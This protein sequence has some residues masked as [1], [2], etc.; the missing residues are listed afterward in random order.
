LE[1]GQGYYKGKGSYPILPFFLAHKGPCI[2]Q[3]TH[4]KQEG[5]SAS[6]YVSVGLPEEATIS[7]EKAKRAEL[8]YIVAR[9]S[10]YA[11]SCTMMSILI[12]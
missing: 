11:Y 12:C 1:G 8:H 6:Y 10:I 5:G 3:E 7:D 9:L 4:I 2:I